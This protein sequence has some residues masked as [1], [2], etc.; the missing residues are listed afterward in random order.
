M[1]LEQDGACHDVHPL[2]S[3]A[4]LLY[5][6][7]VSTNGSRFSAPM[8]WNPPSS[9]PSS[10]SDP[11]PVGGVVFLEADLARYERKTFH[12]QSKGGGE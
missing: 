2:G 1:P 6:A 3:V 11:G 12:V 7:T 10:S 5:G 8:A 9:S 4:P